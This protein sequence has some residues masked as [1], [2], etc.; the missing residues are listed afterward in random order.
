MMASI[1]KPFT[2]IPLEEEEMFLDPSGDETVHIIPLVGRRHDL[3]KTC[4]CHPTPDDE[5]PR[6]FIH[7]IEQ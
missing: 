4:W 6:L 3:S 1:S 7:H 5:E 2:R